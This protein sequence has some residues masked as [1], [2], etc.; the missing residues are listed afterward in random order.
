[1]F[2]AFCSWKKIFKK[3]KE[4]LRGKKRKGKETKKE[5]KKKLD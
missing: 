5:R 1:M 4:I 2:G 3:N